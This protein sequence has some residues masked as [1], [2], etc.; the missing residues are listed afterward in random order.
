MCLFWGVL[1]VFTGVGFLTKLGDCGVFWVVCSALG[2]GFRGVGVH[3]AYV[4]I[5][6]YFIDHPYIWMVE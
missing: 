6:E 2:Y 3:H 5:F 1:W 4:V